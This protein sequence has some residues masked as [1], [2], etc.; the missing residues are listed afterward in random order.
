MH[1]IQRNLKQKI[2]YKNSEYQY[3][4]PFIKHGLEYA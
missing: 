2:T 3:I 4:K 1:L